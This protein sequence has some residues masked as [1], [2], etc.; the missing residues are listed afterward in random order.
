MFTNTLY[1]IHSKINQKYY[2]LHL[3]TLHRLHLIIGFTQIF[4]R[5]D[6][7]YCEELFLLLVNVSNSLVYINNR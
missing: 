1:N 6:F 4:E 3:Y 7:L 2:T 5:Y